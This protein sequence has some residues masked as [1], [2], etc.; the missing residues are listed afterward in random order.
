[1]RSTFA[2]RRGVAPGHPRPPGPSSLDLDPPFVAS[3]M[4]PASALPLTAA[5]AKLRGKRVFRH[6]RHALVVE[7]DAE[8]LPLVVRIADRAGDGTLGRMALALAPPTST[9][10][11]PMLMD[12]LS[13]P[14][15][16]RSA[17]L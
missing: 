10:R 15:A 9:A 17:A 5:D 2:P 6:N 12:G 13:G 14:R 8:L 11:R 4:R 1:V 3:V 7:E 16:C